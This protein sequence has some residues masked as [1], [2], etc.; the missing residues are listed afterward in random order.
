M[1]IYNQQCNN[2]KGPVP[3][4]CTVRSRVHVYQWQSTAQYISIIP[5]NVHIGLRKYKSWECNVWKYR[6]LT[7]VLKG[8][9]FSIFKALKSLNLTLNI[10]KNIG[11]NVIACCQENPRSRERVRNQSSSLLSC[12]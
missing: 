2:L 7:K 10:L 12:C 5:S 6:V 8:I 3:G 9:D 1:L 11:I 4:E